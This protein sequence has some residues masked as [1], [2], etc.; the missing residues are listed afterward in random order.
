VNV[1]TR[2][3]NF[4]SENDVNAIKE[5]PVKKPEKPVTPATKKNIPD[6]VADSA[7]MHDSI[8]V[9]DKN[10]VMTNQ[11]SKSMSALAQCELLCFLLKCADVIAS[12][13]CLFFPCQRFRQLFCIS[14]QH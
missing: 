5:E 1:Q 12:T 4:S 6:E 9:F 3:R 8:V 14:G 2:H 11:R 7:N 13:F 10:K